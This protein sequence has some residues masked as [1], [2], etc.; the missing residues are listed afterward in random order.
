MSVRSHKEM[1]APGKEL[2]LVMVGARGAR[3]K[4]RAFMQ[5]RYWVEGRDY[6]FA[7]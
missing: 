3:E 6:L 4:I 2:I 7:A 5:E 1:P